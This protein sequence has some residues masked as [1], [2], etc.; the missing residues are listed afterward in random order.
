MKFAYLSFVS[1]WS[2]VENEG[3]INKV[4]EMLKSLSAEHELLFIRK[5]SERMIDESTFNL[6]GPITIIE[7]S[8]I[9][10]R[11]EMTLC[12]FGRAVGDFVIEWQAPLNK[13]SLENVQLLLDGTNR[14]YEIVELA[15]VDQSKSSKMFYRF[16]NLFRPANKKVAQTIGLIFS[17]FALSKLIAHADFDVQLKNVVADLPVSRKVVKS[18]DRFELDRAFSTRIRSGF[19][20]LSKGG[21]FGSTIPLAFACFSALI[22][23]FT[24]VYSLVV[25]FAKNKSPEGWTTLMIIFGLNFSVIMLVLSLLWSRLEAIARS[26]SKDLDIT[27]SIS[28]TPPKK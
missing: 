19:I 25:Y 3:D 11:D 9:A 8:D 17:R 6:H 15:A 10:T 26:L 28:V 2:E 1:L 16:V 12:G 24:V 23:L 14:G 22:G 4:D 7:V 20:L 18:L 13:V 27:S 5:Q 21:K